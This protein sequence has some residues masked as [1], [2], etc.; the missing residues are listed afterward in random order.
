MKTNIVFSACQHDCSDNCAIISEVTS[1]KAISIKGNPNHNFTRG[2]LCGKVNNYLER[3][4]SED[5]ILYPMVR[6]GKKGSN[7][8]DRVTW[9]EALKLIRNRFTGSIEKYGSESILP[10]SYLGHQGLLNGLHCG[11]P[12]F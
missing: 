3:V 8:F 12:I 2:T 11:R 6:V 10:Y 1:G 4:Y 7:N 9:E 5:R